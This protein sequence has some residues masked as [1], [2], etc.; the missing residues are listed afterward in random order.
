[1]KALAIVNSHAGQV[2]A[3]GAEGV[4]DA[5]R[6]ACTAAGWT[7]DIRCVEGDEIACAADEVHGHDAVICAGGDG[8]LRC[9]ADAAIRHKV[10]LL[11]LPAGTMNLLCRDLGLP[12]DI[13]GALAAGLTA[14]PR[15]IDAGRIE[16]KEKGARFFFNNVVFGAYAGLADARED[17]RKSEAFEDTSFALL[18]ASHAIKEAANVD[19]LVKMSREQEALIAQSVVVSNN[20]M[21][22][23]VDFLPTRA[24]L[25]EGE[26]AI[27]LIEVRSG[28][29]YL[30]RLIEFLRTA[31]G[32][33]TQTSRYADKSCVVS[34][35]E[36]PIA[37]AVDGDS[38]ESESPVK[39]SIVAGALRVL[40]PVPEPLASE[41]ESA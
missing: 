9:V 28:M 12:L 29:D 24:R 33:S 32:E 36:G 19:F 2:A 26:L 4:T 39:L 17:L 40:A 16:T 30:A 6:E 38:D 22:D 11:P 10:P 35:K 14:A 21:T 3:A 23:V 8:T 27:Y 31:G 1:M 13:P 25:D 5:I 20:F 37:F 34:V 18:E 15:P 41:E 7:V